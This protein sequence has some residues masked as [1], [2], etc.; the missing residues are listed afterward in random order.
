MNRLL[1]LIARLAEKRRQAG[2]RSPKTTTERLA[3]PGLHESRRCG[4]PDP[5]RDR[6]CSSRTT[7]EPR[8]TPPWRAGSASDARAW[9]LPSPSPGPR[10]GSSKSCR[11][12][13][14]PG[15]QIRNLTREWER[16]A[17][18]AHAFAQR[19]PVV[20][21][22][23]V[24]AITLMTSVRPFGV[25]RPPFTTLSSSDVNGMASIAGIGVSVAMSFIDFFP[26]IHLARTIAP[27]S[28][29]RVSRSVLVVTS[30]RFPLIPQ[31]S[32]EI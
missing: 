10:S 11:Q 24:A 15:G 20:G 4:L 12:L 27:P 16:H 26:W 6:D 22:H 31:A 9:W 7:P 32:W 17:A 13:L 18:M 1:K 14:Q 23:V 25:A 3:T 30:V 29:V 28:P 5:E 8:S 2:G 21:S 19:W